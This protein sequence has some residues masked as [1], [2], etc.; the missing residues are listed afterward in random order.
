MVVVVVVVVLKVLERD[1]GPSLATPGLF[2][3][4]VALNHHFHL[5][6]LR[7]LRPSERQAG[8]ARSVMDMIQ[9][10]RQTKKLPFDLDVYMVDDQEHI[11]KCC[12]VSYL[13]ESPKPAR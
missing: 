11:V 2:M 12:P 6:C 3:T 10:L 1:E 13:S 9:E 8:S 5:N 7:P 4:P